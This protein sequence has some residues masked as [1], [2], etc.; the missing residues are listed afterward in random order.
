MVDPFPYP[1]IRLISRP[2]KEIVRHL[3]WKMLQAYRQVLEF[4][5]GDHHATE[6]DHQCA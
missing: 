5:S 2:E 4:G 6:H 3:K 1:D